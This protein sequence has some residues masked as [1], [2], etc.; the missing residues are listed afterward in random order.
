MAKIINTDGLVQVES[1][2]R[3]GSDGRRFEDVVH[4]DTAG[5]ITKQ[6]RRRIIGSKPPSLSEISL[7]RES[8]ENAVK[9]IQGEHPRY[10]M[11]GLKGQ[12]KCNKCTATMHGPICLTP[13]CLTTTCFIE[14]YWKRPTEKRGQDY[15]YFRYKSDNMSFNYDRAIKQLQ[16]MNLDM[17]KGTFRPEEWDKRFLKER[18]FEN[19]IEKW[20]QDK[21]N[22]MKAGRRSPGTLKDYRGYVNKH[23]SF[24][25]GMDVRS[26]T[27]PELDDFVSHL[28]KTV[29]GS[30]TQRNIMFALHNFFKRLKRNRVISVIPEFPT[31]EITNAKAQI[32]LTREEQEQGLDRIQAVF[33]S[34]RIFRDP[35]EFIMHLALR[36]NE[37]CAVHVYDIDEVR[38][39]V[40]IGKTWVTGSV[41]KETTKEGNNE[42]MPLTE[43]AWEIAKRNMEGKRKEDLLFINPL[44]GRRYSDKNLNQTWKKYSGFPHVTFK[45]ASRHSTLSQLNDDSHSGFTIKKVGRQAH[46]QSTDK[47]IHPNE[48]FIREVLENRGRGRR[49]DFPTTSPHLEGKKQ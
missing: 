11:K 16:H 3:R 5:N 9:E 46:I 29:K 31:I 32:A 23:F 17:E 44:T 18:L 22:K 13:G 25:Y 42:W 36:S 26:I 37:G 38:R 41:L 35:M 43:K 1:V 6:T 12:I 45:E 39:R 27:E 14:V 8:L 48:E 10:G 15:Q 20:L 24:F 21:E 47:Y 34:P 7:K 19:E 28:D 4:Y 40:Y 30:K 33:G 2:I 49:G